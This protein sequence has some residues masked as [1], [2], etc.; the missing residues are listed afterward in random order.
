VALCLVAVATGANLRR[1]GRRSEMDMRS[2]LA[3]LE[4]V[5]I[6]YDCHKDETNMIDLLKNVRLS[7]AKALKRIGA[8][9]TAAGEAIDAENAVAHAEVDVESN[10]TARAFQ[11]VFASVTRKAE[12]ALQATLDLHTANVDSAAADVEA[13]EA[14]VAD[15]SLAHNRSRAVHKAVLAE[16]AYAVATATAMADRER[17]E[18]ASDRDAAIG[19]ATEIMEGQLSNA[20]HSFKVAMQICNHTIKQ[21]TATLKGDAATVEQISG[22]VAKLNLCAAGAKPKT[23]GSKAEEKA[24]A[25][26]KT[27][28]ALFLELDA[29]KLETAAC[30]GAATSLQAQA[31]SGLG[32]VDVTGDVAAMKRRLEERTTEVRIRGGGFVLREHHGLAHTRHPRPPVVRPHARPTKVEGRGA[33]AAMARGRFGAAL[34]AAAAVRAVVL[35]PNTCS[36]DLVNPHGRRGP[37]TVTLGCFGLCEER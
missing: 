11:A 36:P 30:A 19:E 6:K 10:R 20:A 24:T 33:P 21:H 3:T 35:R 5:A 34:W 27:G 28:I 13:A 25:P 29:S 2:A 9:C 18:S 15:V 22:F 23:A 32:N 1:H 12:G 31:Q 26:A 7:N 14:K 8:N 4:Q 17:N 16:T 37:C